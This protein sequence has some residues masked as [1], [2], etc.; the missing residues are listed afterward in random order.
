MDAPL[1]T[2]KP[3]IGTGSLDRERVR[4]VLAE[5][6]RERPPRDEA[7]LAAEREII[8]LRFAAGEYAQRTSLRTAA[9]DIGLS[10]MGLRTFLR[11][12][13]PQPRTERKLRS[14]FQRYSTG[15]DF[16]SMEDAEAAITV[17]VRE[18]DREARQPVVEAVLRC[19][20][21][22]YRDSGRAIPAWV[23][24]LRQRSGTGALPSE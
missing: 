23:D 8:E 12:G 18:I 10:P 3:S 7:A 4:A 17:L 21:T 15:R 14:W 13:R 24:E 19:M 20:E 5:I 1:R 9:G 22:G 11:G 16:L 2:I 6:A